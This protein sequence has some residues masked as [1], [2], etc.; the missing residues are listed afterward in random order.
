MPLVK[1]ILCE[2]I[3]L[4]LSVSLCILYLQF[5]SMQSSAIKIVQG[6]FSITN[7]F[8]RGLS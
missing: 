4:T 2:V 7:I 3:V 5:P 1:D 6:V 8:K